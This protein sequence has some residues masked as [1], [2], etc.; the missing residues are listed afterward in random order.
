[1]SCTSGSESVVSERVRFVKTQ[2]LKIP[3]KIRLSTGEIGETNHLITEIHTDCGVVGIGEGTSY[4][5]IGKS[6][7]DIYNAYALCRKVAKKLEGRQ[8]SE[9]RDM[10][11]QIQAN[12]M[13]KSFFDYGPFLALETAVIDAISK[14][15][16][17]MFA[18]TVGKIYRNKV[19]VCGTIFLGTPQKM[20]ES[21][22][23]WI[24]KGVKHL[25]IK[26]TG[27]NTVDSVNLGH[28]RD[29]VGYDPLVRIDANEIYGT[30]DKTIGAINGLNKFEVAVVEQPIKWDDLEGLRRIRRAVAPKIM[31]DEGLRRPSDVDLISEKEA[32]DIINFHPSKLGCLSVTRAAIQKTVDL[33]L[34]Y[35]VGSAV[36]TGIGVA[37]HLNLAASLEKLSYPNEEIG[38]FELFG[39]DIVTNPLKIVHG[40]IEIPTD[41]GIGVRL[42]KEKLKEY[43]VKMISL[44]SL[45][46]NAAN[47]T[48]SKSPRQARRAVRKVL[49]IA[50]K[51]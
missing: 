50:R 15:D 7:T 30:A 28:I 37:A 26:V 29:A 51:F 41:Y 2:V 49:S 31:V 23:K 5:L 43:D 12:L 13:E 10:L 42:D 47:R 9:A 36:M 16:K 8:L 32:A 20:A 21:A 44:R 24:S 6:Y 18:R 45:L 40:Y 38:L 22:Q 33:G 35:M 17:V 1:M 48:Y 39:K 14:L 46:M 19:P 11:P 34:E 4:A 3:V 27:K 25:K